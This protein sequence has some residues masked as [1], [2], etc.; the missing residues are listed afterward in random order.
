MSANAHK[1]ARNKKQPVLEKQADKSL[2]AAPNNDAFSVEKTKTITKSFALNKNDKVSLTNIYGGITVKVWDKNEIKLDAEIKAAGNSNQEAITQ[3][4]RV[5]IVGFKEVNLVS[6]STSLTNEK[7]NKWNKKGSQ[8]KVFYT[9]YMP[10]TN[11][12]GASQKY[13]NIEMP[14]FA[15]ATSLNVEYGD[16]FVGD[17]TSNNNYINVQYGKA[18]F[19][20]INVAK[21]NHQYGGDLTIK[22]VNTLD[23][24]SQYAKVI[25]GT[26]NKEATIDQQYGGGVRIGSVKNLQLKSQYS[27]I[28]IGKATGIVRTK[29]QYSGI[30]IDNITT[31]CKKLELSADYADVSV[32]FGTNFSAEF[33]LGVDYGSF[34][35]GSNVSSVKSMGNDS[36]NSKKYSGKI[37]NGGNG[38]NSAIDIKVAYGSVK[39]N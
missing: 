16:L 4:E 10:A 21:I 3:L 38:N 27:D 28:Q 29:L 30:N 35:Y 33:N 39:F 20:E 18:T 32:G 12:L 7:S 8:L 14:N 1:I 23:L 15:G 19:G 37:G 24:N 22:T 36:G 9:V 17:L 6:F 13:G 34:K 5:S 11:A 31:D 2:I 26:I 25:I